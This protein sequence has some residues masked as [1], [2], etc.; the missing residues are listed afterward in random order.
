MIN[1]SYGWMEKYEC[2]ESPFVDIRN[3]KKINANKQTFVRIDA[4]NWTGKNRAEHNQYE[5]KTPVRIQ[6]EY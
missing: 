1:W 2:N 3:N 4:K 6:I 5:T